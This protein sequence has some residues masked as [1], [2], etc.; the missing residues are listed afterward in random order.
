[1]GHVCVVH[2][3][4]CIVC[5]VLCVVC[6]S[7]MLCDY[8]GQAGMLHHAKSDIVVFF[9]KKNLFIFTTYYSIYYLGFIPVCTMFALTHHP[10]MSSCAHLPTLYTVEGPCHPCGHIVVSHGAHTSES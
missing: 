10:Y 3:V 2:Y 1:M 6:M 8:A 9:F 4:L 7:F 5:Y